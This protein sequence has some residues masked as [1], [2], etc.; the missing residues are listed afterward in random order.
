MSEQTQE[1]LIKEHISKSQDT[2]LC[3]QCLRPWHDGI[4]SCGHNNDSNVQLIKNIAEN[5]IGS[6]HDLNNL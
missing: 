1:F 3:D 5:L 2:D 6:G 4:C